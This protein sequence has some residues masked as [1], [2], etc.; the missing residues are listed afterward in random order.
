MPITT[1]QWISAFL[2]LQFHFV[3][4]VINIFSLDHHKYFN[5]STGSYTIISQDEH[6]YLCSFT[7]PKAAC[8]IMQFKY[9]DASNFVS[10]EE[11][12]FF[13][14]IPFQHLTLLLSNAFDGDLY[15]T[16]FGSYKSRNLVF[17]KVTMDDIKR[18]RALFREI[19]V[20]GGMWPVKLPRVSLGRSG[21]EM[22][23]SIL[24][25]I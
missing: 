7:F 5:F 17:V 6:L 14:C 9:I 20:N 2:R 4:A 12:N 19:W 1:F 23:K 10:W 11:F 16:I 22:R 25:V 18:T 3:A 13:W 24:S 15:N 21:K 8:W